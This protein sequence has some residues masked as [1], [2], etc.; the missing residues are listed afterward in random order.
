[1]RRD[2]DA[3]MRA[4]FAAVVAFLAVVGAD[5][6]FLPVTVAGVIEITD[7]INMIAKTKEKAIPQLKGNLPETV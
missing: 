7:A 5:C 1:M 6:V 2:P 3:V 4:F